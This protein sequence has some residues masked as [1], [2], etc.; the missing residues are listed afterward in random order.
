MTYEKGSCDFRL[1]QDG[2]GDFRQMKMV[3]CFYNGNGV[4]LDR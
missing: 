4:I 2:L 1:I 3:G